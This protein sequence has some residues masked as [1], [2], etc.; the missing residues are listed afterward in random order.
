MNP[1]II[2]PTPLLGIGPDT[3]VHL[4]YAS[5]ALT[6]E[7]YKNHFRLK[8]SMGEAVI[9][10][11]SPAIPRKP[12][13]WMQVKPILEYVRPRAVVLPDWDYGKYRTL[14]IG[15]R[16]LDYLE[17]GGYQVKSIGTIQGGTPEELW[18]CYSLIVKR[19]D[20]IGLP[21]SLEKIQ[22]RNSLVE[23]FNIT[24][25]VVFIETYD[26]Y[27]KEKPTHPNV[28]LYWSSFPYRLGLI[29]RDLSYG[30]RPPPELRWDNTEMNPQI[31]RNLED[32]VKETV[33]A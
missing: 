25:P 33:A 14:R 5:V 3:K 11:H 29:G 9:L 17:E 27:I 12:L 28:D 15:L 23:D 2:V 24:K 31:Q 19:V 26:N 16:F 10:D 13:S 7:Y 21:C 30:N 6:D 8:S 4:C 20:V 22:S 32:Y 1:P 18:D